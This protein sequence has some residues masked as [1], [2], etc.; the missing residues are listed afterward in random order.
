[1]VFLIPFNFVFTIGPVPVA[2][3]LLKVAAWIPFLVTRRERRPFLSS[4][5]NKWFL[6]LAGLLLLSL[7]RAHDLPFTLKEVL[8]QGSNLGLVYLC[9][10]LVDSKEKVLQVLRVLTVSTF[11]VACYGFYQWVIQDFGALFWIV[12]PRLD[13]S[14]AHYRDHFWEWRN[15]II[16]VLISEMELGHYFNLCIPIGLMLWVTEGK[17]RIGSKWLW[18]SLCML[19]G[20][21]LTFTFGAWAALAASFTLFAFLLGKGNRGKIVVAGLLVL[22]LVAIVVAHG[23]L[24]T[25]V[26]QKAV[27]DSIGSFAWDAATRLYG[28]KLALQIWWSHPFIGAGVGNFESISADYDFVLGATSQGSSPHETYL[29]LLANVGIVGALS[30]LVIMFKTIRSNL[31]LMREQTDRSAIAL[32]FAF[33]LT[34]T[35]FGWLSDDSAF[36]GPH[37]SYLLWLLV[38]LS[39]VVARLKTPLAMAGAVKHS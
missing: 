33:A 1:M 23:P 21:V 18:M 20:L 37:A 27:G 6:I 17:R 16:S 3:E 24:R 11:L 15:R 32:A 30:V 9:L 22:S 7:Y 26:E 39:E 4:R 36:L 12:N 14:V 35:M 38:A 2:A 19:A 29:Y 25:V 5:F 8:R 10:N 13:T 34:T 28:W 31:A